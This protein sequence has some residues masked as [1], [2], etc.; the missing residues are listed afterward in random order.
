M[1]R[2]TRPAIQYLFISLVLLFATTGTAWSQGSMELTVV[3]ENGK[4]LRDVAVTA[5]LEGGSDVVATATTNKKGVAKADFPAAGFYI[6]TLDADGYPEQTARI[7]IRDAMSTTFTATVLSPEA[8]RQQ[9][10]VDA[11][12]AGVT[13]L[14]TPGKEG[15]A[16]ASFERAVEIN[17]ELVDA[18][19]L[20]AILATSDENLEKAEPAVLKFLEMRPEGIAEIALAAH[21]V[22][23]NTGKLDQLGPVRDALIATGGSLA[24]DVA[25]GTFNEGVAFLRDDKKDEA[26][27]RFREATLVAPNLSVAHRS[28]AALEFNDGNY[29]AALPH[30]EALL[31]IDPKSR[32][33]N[34]MAFFTHNRLGNTDAARMAGKAW[35]D[36]DDN[37][38]EEISSQ[39]V[40]FFE[41]NEFAPAR[42][43]M[44]LALDIA[45]DSAY[46]NYT[47]GRVL[48]GA[49][50]IPKAKE[51]LRRFL[52][53]APN[54]PEASSAQAMLDGL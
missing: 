6:L 11:F 45:P 30:L 19:R 43:L 46:A 52:E 12:N 47:M 16:L 23:R 22:F 36:A 21:Y 50:D 2:P 48:A 10:S 32:D 38:V 53:L 1:T 31:E 54:H 18:Y 14:R 33:G 24:T 9:Q 34:R 5:V 13:A 20:I 28:L 49:G 37:A 51:H 8:F 44:E 15:D 42:K 17:P 27:E 40:Q 3:D 4:N 25:A 7:E 39:A 29:E 26:R 41:N 35:A